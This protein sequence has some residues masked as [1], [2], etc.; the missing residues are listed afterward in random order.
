MAVGE[1]ATPC[2]PQ[3]Y[4]WPTVDQLW[5]SMGIYVRKSL[6][7]GPFRFNLSK[8][9]VGISTGV[10]GFRVG[11]GPRGNYVRV[12]AHGVY[13]RSSLSSGQRSNVKGQVHS[14]PVVITPSSD[15]AMEDITGLTALELAPSS[16]D[17]LVAQ[18][19]SAG[20]VRAWWPLLL[21]V[22]ILGWIGA[23]WLR[24][25]QH[26]KRSVVVFYEVETSGAA[27]FETLVASWAPYASAAGIW[28]ETASGAVRTTQQYK[29]NAGASSLIN[30]VKAA[31][32][33]EAP[34]ELVTNI[35]V[36]TVGAGAQSLHFLPDRLL[37]RTGRKFSDVPY[38][39]LS[40]EFAST[41]YIESGRVPRDAVQVGT[42][43]KYVN[44]KGGPD[45]RY[46][47]NPQIPILQYAETRLASPGGLAWTV[48]CS[49]VEAARAATA[50]LSKARTPKTVAAT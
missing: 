46:K 23:I 15:I 9:G 27:W 12:G 44:V 11:T 16:A 8:S 6:K 26:A 5:G 47:D 34:K 37:I 40:V 4:P 45:R 18:L 41:R 33:L 7:A 42:T 17:D 20:T 39:Q 30:R 3:S 19:N 35:A 32:S 25:A 13:Y 48:Q 28:R 2:R 21:I 36:P 31:L 14:S 49:K 50:A 29:T 43:W 38:D 22:P 10:P 24:Y 1:A